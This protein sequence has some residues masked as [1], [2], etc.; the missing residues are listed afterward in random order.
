MERQARTRGEGKRALSQ[1]QF[2]VESDPWSLETYLPGLRGT[3]WIVL[4]VLG[5][6]LVVHQVALGI[7]MVS[8]E[9]RYMHA[10]RDAASAARRR[11]CSG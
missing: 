11:P 9:L 8:A 7:Q 4:A 3:E 2:A 1:R 6:V 5:A 10:C